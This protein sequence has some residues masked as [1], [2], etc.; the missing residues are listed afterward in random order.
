LRAMKLGDQAFFY[1]SNEGPIIAQ[2]IIPVNHTHGAKEMQQ[3]GRDVEQMVLAKALR[4]VFHER[5]FVYG[6]K[7]V[8]FD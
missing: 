3:A 6:N 5:V 8:I 4:L 1:H 7:T 2:S